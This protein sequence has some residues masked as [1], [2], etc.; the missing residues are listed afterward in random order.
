MNKG[1]IG[2]IALFVLVVGAVM[3]F[4]G[5]NRADTGDDQVKNSDNSSSEI[6]K[7]EDGERIV[8]FDDVEIEFATSTLFARVV[9]QFG[10]PVNRDYVLTDA[11]GEEVAR[12]DTVYSRGMM[13]KT[14]VE[15]VLRTHQLPPGTYTLSIPEPL[16]LGE[17]NKDY[18][19]E[20]SPSWLCRCQPLSIEVEIT[21]EGTNLG[22]IVFERMPQV[23]IG[24]VENAVGTRLPYYD[25]RYISV[26]LADPLYRQASVAS[27]NY[28]QHEDY[29]ATNVDEFPPYFKRRSDEHKLGIVKDPISGLPT[30]SYMI[31]VVDT[32]RK[33]KPKTIEFTVTDK[34]VD[35]ETIVLEKA[36]N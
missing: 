22:E 27:K 34:D 24:G 11:L 29:F 23:R 13:S 4:S 8:V 12:G 3:V 21:E 15:G 18:V 17:Q 2:V 7:N 28:R 1:V 30:G 35:L 16:H 20:K 33:Y 32:E 9:D 5:G 31:E 10:E 36:E 6:T 25:Y 26:E 14:R 19:N